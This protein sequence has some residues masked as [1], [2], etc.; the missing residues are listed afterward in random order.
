MFLLT[1]CVWINNPK[2]EK[3]DTPNTIPIKTIIRNLI[4]QESSG[5]HSLK[6]RVVKSSK[7]AIGRFQITK[8][9]LEDYNSFAGKKKYG[10][11]N[12]KSPWVNR[13]VGQWYLKRYIRYFTRRGFDHFDTTVLA[14]NTY[15]QGHGNT[16]KGKIYYPYVSN[17]C[18][19][20]FVYF[21]NRREI[22][23]QGTAIMKIKSLYPQKTNL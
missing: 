11:S 23:N 6:G 19:E 8:P 2:A 5:H 1:A 4:H 16:E 20:Y 17:I 22:T 13:E 15:N 7:G 3:K 18:P 9:A 21:I 10:M 12:L 14:V